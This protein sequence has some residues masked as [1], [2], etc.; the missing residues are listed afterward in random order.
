[1]ARQAKPEIAPVPTSA[2]AQNYLR[3]PTFC[4]SFAITGLLGAVTAP[5]AVS[6]I[7]AKAPS[8]VRFLLQLRNRIGAIVGLRA[9]GTPTAQAPAQLSPFP[10]VSETS[11]RVVM[12]FDDW[13]LNFRIVVDALSSDGHHAVTVTTLVHTNNWAG[14]AYLA[15]IMPFHLRIVPAM[16]RTLVQAKA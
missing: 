7:F 15:L 14:K 5:M 10:I 1:M 4:D 9:A 6:L 3:A 16:L 13:H 2:S 11:D 12:G 8:W